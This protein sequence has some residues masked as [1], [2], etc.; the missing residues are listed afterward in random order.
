MI[1]IREGVDLK[2]SVTPGRS[3]ALVFLHGGLGNRF[4]WRSQFEAA[5]RQGRQALAYDLGGHG[6]SSPYQRY[7]IDR[8]GRD[9]VVAGTHRKGHIL[10]RHQTSKIPFQGLQD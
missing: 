9:L 8:H 7:S 2:V 5:R 1:R 3:P 4:N 6:A 10:Q